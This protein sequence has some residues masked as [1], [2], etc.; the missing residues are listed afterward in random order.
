MAETVGDYLSAIAR[1]ARELSPHGEQLDTDSALLALWYDR[2]VREGLHVGWSVRQ[3]LNG[4]EFCEALAL[5]AEA[6]GAFAFVTLQQFVANLFLG[7][8][9]ADGAPWPVVGVAFGHLRKAGGEAPRGRAGAVAGCVPWLTG[10][11]VFRQ[12]VLGVRGDEEAELYLLVDATDRPM[13][14]HGADMPLIAASSTRTVRIC[15]QDL[16]IDPGSIL[17]ID[18]ASALAEGDRNGVLYQTPLMVGCVRACLRLLESARGV[19]AGMRDRSIERAQALL[20]GVYA[21][22]D[23]G[24]PEEGRRLRATLADFSV[25]LAR[26]TVMACGGGALLTTHAAQRLYREALL[27]S[28]MAQTPEIVNRAFEEV[29][30]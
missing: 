10:A 23:G 27:Y 14:R 13:F 5:C 30:P 3:P 4:R 2:F 22:F 28:V 6:S 7:G 26:L 24:T 1:F 16:P 20:A 11:G 15:V 9:A 17:K 29:F 8:R 25:R 21:A 19:E 12:V 18:P